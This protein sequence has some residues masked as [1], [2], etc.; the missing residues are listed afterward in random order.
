M[1]RV[2]GFIRLI[3]PVNSLMTGLAVIVGAS[4]V[5]PLKILME[6]IFS[7]ILG[8]V[9][10]FT[11]TAASMAINDYYDREIDLVNEPDYPIPSGLVKPKESLIFAAFLTLIGLVA[12]FFT[13]PLC[14]MIAI[15]FWFFSVIYS[16]KGK[17]T[18]LPGN[19]LVSACVA[20]TF[21]YGSFIVGRSLEVNILFFAALA[22]IS[23]TGREI[24]KG[25]AD[26]KGDKTKNMRTL[27]VVYGE[28]FA[29]FIASLF[30]L[31]AVFSSLFPVLLNLVSLWFIPFV[32]ITNFGF[33]I[34][35]ISIIRNHTKNNA[36]KIKRQI[37]FFML[38]GLTAFLIGAK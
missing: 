36:K 15:V 33:I 4:L 21:V 38:M 20:S 30:F 37:L 19:F 24:L 28:K 26:I 17:C 6:N 27:A 13:N 3:R 12:A 11:L 7:L 9:T 31:S 18:G 22:F 8:Y 1:N 29:S 10:A 16:T 2:K 32:T 34:S 35:S 5:V 23:N 25:I 14:F